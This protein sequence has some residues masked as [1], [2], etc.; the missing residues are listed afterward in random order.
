M[1]QRAP[2]QPGHTLP[3]A[4][5]SPRL[6]KDRPL[7]PGRCQTPGHL[8]GSPQG[9]W[10]IQEGES[11]WLA[12]TGVAD[13]ALHHA[14]PPLW[15]GPPGS[16]GGTG[17]WGSPILPT[18]FV[19][20]PHP[21]HPS[22]SLPPLCA[23][24][25][26]EPMAVIGAQCQ[27]LS[28]PLQ[29]L[30]LS[31]G[32]WGR[33]FSQSLKQKPLWKH[34]H[35]LL[36]QRCHS[37]SASLEPLP[38]NLLGSSTQVKKNKNPADVSDCKVHKIPFKGNFSPLPTSPGRQE[39]ASLTLAPSISLCKSQSVTGAVDLGAGTDPWCSL[40]FGWTNL[41]SVVHS[42]GQQDTRP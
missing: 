17:E 14:P 6:A 41:A 11:P 21:P 37:G 22:T 27:P 3:S 29:R 36:L 31:P 25:S 32:A 20:P 1:L 34:Q 42:W 19:F 2:A 16:C 4:S 38:E 12:C 26:A 30:L 24:L 35:T 18:S 7:H 15:Q 8:K 33:C 40:G 39:P 5:L 13:R 9:L 23:G 28:P 10:A